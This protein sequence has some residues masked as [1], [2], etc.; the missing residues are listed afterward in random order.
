MNKLICCSI[1]LAGVSAFADPSIKP[2][3]VK[4]SQAPNRLVT[5]EYEVQN[6]PAI[7]T[8]DILT[9]G[10]SIG[11]ENFVAGLSG[12]ANRL[13]AVGKH[14]VT[15]RPDRTWEGHVF[16]HAEV[17]ASVTA[18]A[19]NQPPDYMAVDLVAADK[20][21]FY[22][23]TNALPKPLSDDS[24]RRDW[25]LLRKIPAAN[26]AWRMG[27]ASTQPGSVGSGI[28]YSANEI[29]HYVTLTEDYFLGV[30][31]ATYAQCVNIGTVSSAGHGSDTAKYRAQDAGDLIAAVDCKMADLR[32]NW[33]ALQ[34]IT[35]GSFFGKLRAKA[36]GKIL[37]DLPT[38][39]Q[40]EFACR[41]GQGTG[42][43]SGEEISEDNRYKDNSLEVRLDRLGWYSQNSEL[44]IASA[45]VRTPH[46]VGE[47]DPNGYGLYDM[48]GNA[49]EMC[50]D[51][52]S[53]GA[54][55]S[56]GS[57]EID[58]LQETAGS[59][60]LRGGSF[61]ATAR[62]CRCAYRE[63]CG[64]GGTLSAGFRVYCP[65]NMGEM[66]PFPPVQ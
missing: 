41:A 13:V 44:E 26:V 23:S 48:L 54:S 30:F 36:S 32:G 49:G 19:T 22:T 9:N 15:W 47:K 57:D 35:D 2:A 62:Q 42:L 6:E 17:K 37:F 63:A 61:A 18:W 25:L 59:H 53:S 55:Y 21:F 45:N 66:V 58:P 65:V 27:A 31:E 39:A 16:E 38:D 12:A 56:D 10:V 11:A 40:W 60:L 24:W 4:L 28:D 7:V 20:V 34:P 43:Y 29:P 14:R 8:V 3:S 51:W 5:I 50:R 1:V 33:Q 46:R 64:T 52:F